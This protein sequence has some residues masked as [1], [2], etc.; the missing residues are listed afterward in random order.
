MPEKADH[1]GHRQ[2][3]KERFKKEGLSN[4]EVH[5]AMEL[6][7]FYS[8]PYKDTND[9]AHLLIDRF[10]S[11]RN[12]IDAP[13]EELIKVKGVGENSALLIKLIKDILNLSIKDY[14]KNVLCLSDTWISKIY[15]QRLLMGKT[16]EEVH[17]ICLDNSNNV[18]HHEEVASGTVNRTNVDLRLIIET[19]LRH[20]SASIIVAHNHPRGSTQPSV[21]DVEFTANLKSLLFTLGIHLEDH[22]IVGEKDVVS[23]K[24]MTEYRA[25]F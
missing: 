10:G 19:A 23:M 3:L 22:I 5:N 11:L 2:R 1:S 20:N 12:V 6:L 14:N 4:F 8:V 24:E 17:V 25:I 9:I 21:D 15:C 16:V 13:Y 7:L 18:L